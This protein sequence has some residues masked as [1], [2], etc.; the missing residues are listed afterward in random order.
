MRDR[1]F[2]CCDCGQSWA[3]TSC[4]EG[5]K[6]GYDI[7]CPYCGGASK[8]RITEDGRKIICGSQHDEKE[9]RLCMGHRTS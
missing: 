4:G 9:C 2:E 5:A 8:V 1:V 3:E 7:S 6:H